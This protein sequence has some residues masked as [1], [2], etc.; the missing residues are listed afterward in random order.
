MKQRPSWKLFGATSNHERRWGWISETEWW[1]AIGAERPR[2]KN[3]CLHRFSR[4]RCS[5]ENGF[6]TAR[7]SMRCLSLLQYPVITERPQTF[8]PDS[9]G[10]SP[11][12]SYQRLKKY[13]WNLQ[14][15]LGTWVAFLSV[16]E[17][18]RPSLEFLWIQSVFEDIFGK[19]LD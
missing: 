7:L 13:P 10:G 2:N 3:T 5:E 1:T 17:I 11:F 4:E 18:C 19:S 8:Q 15:K 16:F 14:M 6:E 12:T 9:F